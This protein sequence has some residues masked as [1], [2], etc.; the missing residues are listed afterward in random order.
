[1]RRCSANAIVGLLSVVYDQHIGE[2][3][4]QRSQSPIGGT[5]GWSQRSN[6]RPVLRQI[7]NICAL[8]LAIVPLTA[9][10]PSR[11]ELGEMLRIWLDQE[12]RSSVP[13]VS[14]LEPFRPSYFD[15]IQLRTETDRLDAARQRYSVRVQPKLPHLRQAERAMQA[16]QR[17][18]LEVRPAEA[19]AAL[20]GEALQ[21]VFVLAIAQGEARLLD[22]LIDLQAVL[23]RVSRE[24]LAEFDFDVERLLDAEDEMAELRLERERLEM[25]LRATLPPLPLDRLVGATDIYSLAERLLTEA[26]RLATAR[27]SAAALSVLDAEAA[28]VKAENWALIDFLQGDYR[29]DLLPGRERYS[30]G[31]GIRLP[32]SNKRNRSLDEVAVERELELQRAALDG[33]DAKREYAEAYA[34]LQ[35]LK[36]ECEA[37]RLANQERRARRAQ[38]RNV[39]ASS[40]STRPDA[41]LRLDRRDLLDRAELVELE[42]EIVLRY[43]EWLAESGLLSAEALAEWALREGN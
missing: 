21:R 34:D 26:P 42:G 7:I 22:S 15:R 20:A 28:L 35:L 13:G 4:G 11:Q 25:R 14:V 3:L 9:Q 37:Q 36:A 5:G 24:R 10:S 40:A 19:E 23:V 2:P 29:S 12:A 33:E 41:L 17:T 6:H 43:A 32:Q 38:L 16:A 8:L 30:V 18:T 31:A 39:L 27:R 1:M